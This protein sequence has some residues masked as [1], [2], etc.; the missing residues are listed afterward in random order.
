MSIK[1][2]IIIS[3]LSIH[4]FKEHKNQTI[5]LDKR[6]IYPQTIVFN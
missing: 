6:I 4:C 5:E 2:D 3:I 1:I